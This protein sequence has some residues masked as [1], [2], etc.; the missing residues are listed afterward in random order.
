[1][2]RIISLLAS[3]I[4]SILLA[5]TVFSQSNNMGPIL[6]SLSFFFFIFTLVSL[7]QRNKKIGEVV[8]EFIFNFL[9]W[10]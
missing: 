10:P 9:M 1:M 8:L 2:K 4:L 3:A 7:Y 5:A 6:I